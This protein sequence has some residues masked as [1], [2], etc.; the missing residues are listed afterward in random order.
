MAQSRRKQP[1]EK[2]ARVF[3]HIVQTILVEEDAQGEI[4]REV[5]LEPVVCYNRNQLIEHRKSSEE[6]AKASIPEMPG[7]AA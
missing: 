1:Q 5:V 7:G 2:K 6:L 4:L 3:K